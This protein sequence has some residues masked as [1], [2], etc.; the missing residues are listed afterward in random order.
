MTGLSPDTTYYFALKAA[1]EVPLWSA[2]SNV[3]TAY[4]DNTPPAAVTDL[5]ATVVD[6]TT[7]QLSWTAPGDDGSTGA[8][9]SYDIRYSTIPITND[10]SFAAATAVQNPP[11]PQSAG[12]SEALQVTGLTTGVQYWFALKSSDEAGNWSAL[13]N[14]V[15]ATPQ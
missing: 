11:T 1:D 3:A 4:T 10:A 13:S 8:A 7:V 12:G 15:T 9:A 2:I 6:A 14:I 5:A